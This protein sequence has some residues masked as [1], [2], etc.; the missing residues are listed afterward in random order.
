MSEQVSPSTGGGLLS[1][2]LSITP[3]DSPSVASGTVP[4]LGGFGAVLNQQA[5][6]N[7][8]VAKFSGGGML[9][10]EGDVLPQK[11]DQ[12]LPEEQMQDQLRQIAQLLEQ[13][14]AKDSQLPP[15]LSAELARAL[16]QYTEQQP[17][18]PVK[19][20]SE[21]EVGTLPSN[22]DS[23]K[24]VSVPS[25]PGVAT[26]GGENKVVIT[27][28]P[29]TATLDPNAEVDSTQQEVEASRANANS[30]QASIEGAGNSQ[31]QP[32]VDVKSTASK[33]SAATSANSVQLTEVQDSHQNL[34]AKDNANA[35]N[36]TNVA[37]V[38]A[39]N[40]QNQQATQQSLSQQN[41]QQSQ[42]TVNA[43]ADMSNSQQAVANDPSV[44]VGVP[45]V[46]A[47]ADIKSAP[48]K[49]ENP[50]AGTDEV[51]LFDPTARKVEVDA[52]K[53]AN[54]AVTEPPVS[55]QGA[56]S[57][58]VLNPQA[59]NSSIKKIESALDM[60]QQ[61]MQKVAASEKGDVTATQVVERLASNTIGQV[62]SAS[63]TAAQ[64]VVTE[65]Q[66]LMMPQNVKV[67]TPAWN[68]A[69][70]ERAIMIAA[71]NT[72]VAEIKLDP[73]ELGSLNIRVNINQDQVSLN[74][75]S[76][77]AHVR[78]AVEQSLPRLREMFAEQGLALQD[79][80]VSDQSADQQR[81]EQFADGDGSGNQYGGGVG[82][83]GEEGAKPE[84][85]R[86]VSLVD[87][88]A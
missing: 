76:P 69:L 3:K 45:S 30:A 12:L 21:K 40:I 75:T 34:V 70:G 88:Y 13:Q 59:D 15:E 18:M 42:V 85:A 66:N 33:A 47:Q 1:L 6:S 81:R 44:K 78:D 17:I 20:D 54:R 86:S 82:A 87:Y 36:V 60:T 37:D 48:V 74:F 41:I 16:R 61:L 79:S 65:G 8:P 46:N 26:V 84:N 19:G 39:S 57:D 56:K 9:P 73:P 62:N 52:A 53:S 55:V 51:K 28:P 64:K 50:V 80:S 24:V 27:P 38:P 67:N 5:D 58:L 23:D 4:L 25:N 72:R 68:N 83:E 63:P 11:L 43:A 7:V 49:G 32:S 22:A 14:S 10:Q 2:N 71:Q 77:H 31:T 35:A 29:K